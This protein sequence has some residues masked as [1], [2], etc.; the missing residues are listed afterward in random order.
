MNEAIRIIEQ[1]IL[2]LTDSDYKHSIPDLERIQCQL[3]AKIEGLKGAIIMKRRKVK[4]FKKAL[5]VLKC[6]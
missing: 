2:E 1:K 4:E 6:K 3:K 5:E